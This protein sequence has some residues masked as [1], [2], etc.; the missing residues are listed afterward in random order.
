MIIFANFT[1]A[2]APGFTRRSSVTGNVDTEKS[3]PYMLWRYQ[4]TLWR[5]SLRHEHQGQPVLLREDR[6]VQGHELHR[7]RGAN[8]GAGILLN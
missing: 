1:H 6:G 8:G 5:S 7:G 3:S 4:E 2:D